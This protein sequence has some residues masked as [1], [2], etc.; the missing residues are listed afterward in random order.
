MSLARTQGVL[1]VVVVAVVKLTKNHRCSCGH[2]LRF[3]I[4][5]DHGNGS[6]ER[7][8]NDDT[9]QNLISDPFPCRSVGVKGIK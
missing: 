6:L 1:V 7:E 5:L 8:S 3:R 9:T 4:D 2:I